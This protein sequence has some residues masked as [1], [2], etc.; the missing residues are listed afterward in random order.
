MASLRAEALKAFR[1]LKMLITVVCYLLLV[2]QV[3]A[4]LDEGIAYG[5]SGSVLDGS[6][7]FSDYDS[8]I[9]DFKH[10]ME[11]DSVRV[12]MDDVGGTSYIVGI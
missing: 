6:S 10:G 7:E 1:P 3:D 5:N 12:C 4:C 11:V 9:A 2:S 8:L